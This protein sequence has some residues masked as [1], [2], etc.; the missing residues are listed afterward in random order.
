MLLTAWHVNADIIVAADGTGNAKSVQEA[1]DKVPS[2]NKQRIV[3][4]IKPGTYL[5]QIRVPVDK[6]YI[7][8]IGE[9]AEENEDHIQS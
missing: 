9:S 6:P 7:S 1:I 2:N 5:E 8:F 4:R 3:I